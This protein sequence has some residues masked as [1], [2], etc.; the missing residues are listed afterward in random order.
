MS[1]E[2]I[3]HEE[4]EGESGEDKKYQE[5]VVAPVRRRT[6]AQ[7]PGQKKSAG[8]QPDQE[9]CNTTEQQLGDRHDYFP[10]S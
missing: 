8:Y 9:T 3:A 2:G 4:A 7:C 10:Y 6:R 1:A 5:E